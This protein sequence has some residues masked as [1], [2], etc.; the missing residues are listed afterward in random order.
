[1]IMTSSLVSPP[2]PPPPSSSSSS[3][4]RSLT[5]N[6]KMAPWHR[7]FLFLKPSFLG[8]MLNLG[9]V[10]SSPSPLPE[11][12]SVSRHLSHASLWFLSNSW[13]RK[14]RTGAWATNSRDWAHFPAPVSKTER[15]I[16]PSIGVLILGYSQWTVCMNPLNGL[17]VWCWEVWLYE[18]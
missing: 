12:C 18:L 4:S 14:P 6:L 10:S 16:C 9:R 1:M 8:S 15:L 5:R 11:V 17:V 13:K 3:P 7:R 2:P